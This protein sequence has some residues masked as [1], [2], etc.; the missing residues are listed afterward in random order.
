MIT[1]FQTRNP[2]KL[3]SG[4]VSPTEYANP[5]HH[6][7][8]NPHSS[9]QFSNF[10]TFSKISRNSQN[11]GNEAEQVSGLKP[12]CLSTQ[13]DNAFNSDRFDRKPIGRKKYTAGTVLY[14]QRLSVSPD[15]ILSEDGTR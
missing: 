9:K 11:Q 14:K 6:N 10:Q 3:H 12:Q 4:L 8:F 13:N 15:G 2:S 7:P 5:H 1:E